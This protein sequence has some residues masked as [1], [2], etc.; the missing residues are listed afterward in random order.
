M[1]R[2]IELLTEIRD[3]LQGMAEA[4]PRQARRE[5]GTALRATVTYAVNISVKGRLL[6]E[7]W[8]QSDRRRLKQIVGGPIPRSSQR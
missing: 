2:E 7:A 4:G 3:L 6:V 5:S 1:S 8:K